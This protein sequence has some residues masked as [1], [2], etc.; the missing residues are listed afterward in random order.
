[1]YKHT[2]IILF[3]RKNEKSMHKK[4]SGR[5]LRDEEKLSVYLCALFLS[6]LLVHFTSVNITR[7]L[8]VF[9]LRVRKLEREGV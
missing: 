9:L 6:I 7:S 1:M 5:E 4:R 2:S 8:H 3:V